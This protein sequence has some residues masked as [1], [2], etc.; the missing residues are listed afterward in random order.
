MVVA[1]VVTVSDVVDGVEDS[2]FSVLSSTD[3]MLALRLLLQVAGILVE[4][5]PAAYLGRGSP[6]SVFDGTQCAAA[7]CVA[8][9]LS[10]NYLPCPWAFPLFYRL[11]RKKEDGTRAKWRLG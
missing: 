8:S 3:P 6:G 11:Q 1:A 2:D 9:P 10:Y 5:A 7:C 4:V